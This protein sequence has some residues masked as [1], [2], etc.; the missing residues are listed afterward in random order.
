MKRI[1]THIL[2]TSCGKPA[3]AVFVRLDFREPSG[4]WRQLCSTQTDAD[5][6]CFQ[7]LPD[8]ESLAEGFYRLTFDT[9]AYFGSQG[10]RGLYPFVEIAFHAR[11]GESHFHIPLLLSPNGYTT[12]RGS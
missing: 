2:D 12:Y 1:S 3:A 5:G 10:V 8:E 9:A 11:S 7:L 6:R 4:A